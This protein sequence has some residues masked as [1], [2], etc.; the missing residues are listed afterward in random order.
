MRS[1]VFIIKLIRWSQ[2]FN[3]KVNLRAVHIVTWIH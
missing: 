2:V 3:M 1:H